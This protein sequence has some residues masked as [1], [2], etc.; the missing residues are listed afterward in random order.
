MRCRRGELH[1]ANRI[2]LAA[3]GTYMKYR[4]RTPE[5]LND[6]DSGQ[7]EGYRAEEGFIMGRGCV[8]A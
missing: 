4:L 8:S 1:G 7:L 2:Q 6:Y 3:S 5:R